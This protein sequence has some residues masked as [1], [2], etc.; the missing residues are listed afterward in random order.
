MSPTTGPQ[1]PAQGY[2]EVGLWVL[3]VTVVLI[4]CLVASG[5]VA[6]WF[7]ALLADIGG[8]L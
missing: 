7:D 1:L 5:L 4:A 2:L 3:L 8:A 6:G